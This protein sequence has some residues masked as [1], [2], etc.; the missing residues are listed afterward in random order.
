MN[1]P[2]LEGLLIAMVLAPGTYAR[3]RFFA[4]HTRPEVI[5]V[6]RR[7]TLVRGIIRHLSRQ[8]ALT[9]GE[10]RSV[11][12]AAEGRLTRTYEVPSVGLVRKATLDPIELALVRFTLARLPGQ[13]GPLGDD[14]PDRI[15]IETALG[16]LSPRLDLPPTAPPV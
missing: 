9:A 11:V 8:S 15:R 12:P 13:A 10:I 3:N 4:L 2:D 5:K 7:A 14:D 16:R 6:R 1:A